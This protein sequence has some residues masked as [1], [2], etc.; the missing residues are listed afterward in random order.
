MK[1]FVFNACVAAAATVAASY[2]NGAAKTSVHEAAR[3]R[4]LQMFTEVLNAALKRAGEE[5]PRD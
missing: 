1:A 3:R 5:N 2:G 4:T